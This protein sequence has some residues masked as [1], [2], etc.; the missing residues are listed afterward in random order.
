MARNVF[1]TIQVPKVAS[2]YFDLSH[3]VKLSF[4]M[5]KLVPICAMDIIPGDRFEI[6]Y[7]AMMRFSALIAPVMHKVKIT[8]HYFF[9]PN[10]ILWEN[11][12]DF[13]TQQSDIEA[14]YIEPALGFDANRV[15]RKGSIGDYMGLPILDTPVAEML[16]T[17][18]IN[19]LP[20]AAYWKIMAEYYLDQN[21][22]ADVASGVINIE[23]ANMFATLSDG[24]N[25]GLVDPF[26]MSS[27]CFGGP[28]GMPSRAWQHD[29][30][31]GCLP[32]AQKGDQ[33]EMP[34]ADF[35]DVPVITD[36]L[37]VPAPNRLGGLMQNLDGTVYDP[38]TNSIL[39][40][41][42][43]SGR[44]TGNEDSL[45]LYYDPA[46]SMY[47][48]TSQLSASS[49]SINNLRR[50]F[51]LQEWLER[52]ARGGTRY[53]ESIYSHFNERSPDSRLQ[54]PE[55]IGGAVQNMVISEVLSTAQTINAEGEVVNPVGQ[56]SGH[57]ISVGGS[58]VLRYH[59]TEHGWI[60]G[61]VSVQP[62]TAY[63]QGIHK[64]FT[65]P[66]VFD[67]LW[68]TFAHIGEQEVISREVYVDMSET[69]EDNE[70]VFGYLPRYTEYRFENNRVA[71]EFRDTLDFWHMG[72]IFEER[73]LLNSQFISA[74][75]TTRIFAVEEGDHIYA[76][77]LLKIKA[78]RK[79]PKFGTPTF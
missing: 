28:N 6:S 20:F 74:D 47:A 51:R 15:I 24:D 65:R 66:D 61:I 9:V 67:Y 1:N 5:G 18:R 37:T 78:R 54:R 30:F 52:N 59:A 44:V 39:Y 25:S 50:A 27:Y 48:E 19:A 8:H 29:Y 16:Y 13:I 35:N 72:R 2:N 57:G 69:E 31:T 58:K 36:P 68:P 77:V 26:S 73:P 22:Q 14:P 71:G 75:P 62:T 45:P 76:H 49:A 32:F 34:I 64:K 38:A 41:D 43:V 11:W 46:G 10:R 63:Q 55:Y 3:D 40:A 4:Q 79:L 70:Q 60:I 12:E 56:M 21:L 7:E 42:G 17:P 23:Q 53:V 33:V